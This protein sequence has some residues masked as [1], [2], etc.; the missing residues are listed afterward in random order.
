M[1]KGLSLQKVSQPI[2]QNK[3]NKWFQKTIHQKLTNIGESGSPYHKSDKQ[4]QKIGG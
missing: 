4:F 1:I 3:K 2:L